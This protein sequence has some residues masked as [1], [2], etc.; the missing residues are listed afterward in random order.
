MSWGILGS[1]HDAARFGILVAVRCNGRCNDEERPIMVRSCLVQPAIRL[2]GD[3]VRGVLAFIADGIGMVTTHLRFPIRV[4]IG[5]EKKVGPV[6]TVDGR[7]SVVVYTMRVEQLSCVIR[8]VAFC[9]QPDRK[10]ILIEAVLDKNWIAPVWR[11]SAPQYQL[12]SALIS[13]LLTNKS[14]TFV[15]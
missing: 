12:L 10:P 5:V 4:C 11:K 1:C 3:H 15:L 7:I 14:V 8:V 6:E 13:A 9:L 2:L